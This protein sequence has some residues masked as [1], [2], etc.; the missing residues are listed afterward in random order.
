VNEVIPA[1]C[2]PNLP[3]AVAVA[4]AVKVNVNDEG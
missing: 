3:V 1:L 2:S 4:V